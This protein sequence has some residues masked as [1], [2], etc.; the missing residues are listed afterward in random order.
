MS[1][2]MD[3]LRLPVCQLKRVTCS[4]WPRVPV[5]ARHFVTNLGFAL[6]RNQLSDE[7]VGQIGNILGRL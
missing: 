4:L 2:F 7:N 3:A 6:E 1:G 5:Q